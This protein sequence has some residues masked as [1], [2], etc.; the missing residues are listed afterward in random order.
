MSSVTF[1]PGDHILFKA[2]CS[3]EGQL[4]LHG[5]GSEDAPNVIDAYGTWESETDKPSIN[6]CG[7]VSAT[8]LLHNVE[9]WEINNLQVTNLGPERAQWRVAVLVSVENFG[10]MNHIHLLGLFI[11]DVNGELGV[12]GGGAGVRLSTNEAQALPSNLNDVLIENCHFLAVDNI[13]VHGGGG[14]PTT[15]VGP[16]ST[17]VCI[18][19]NFFEDIGGAAVCNIDTDGCVIEGNRVDRAVQREG[20]CAI[21]PWAANNTVI[22][23]NEVYNTGDIGDG[24]AFDS[25]YYCDGTIIQHNYSHDNPGGFLRICNGDPGAGH[26]NRNTVVRY[27]ISV[28][29]GDHDD[30]V[31]ELWKR[32]DNCRVYGNVVYVATG[33]RNVMLVDSNRYGGGEG[34]DQLLVRQRL[35]RVSL[36]YRPVSCHRR[37]NEPLV[38]QH[39]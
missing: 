31:I 30:A 24:E 36:Q 5:S 7:T 17:N 34:G 16:M 6:G 15:K 13:G 2:G 39:V 10:V 32:L 25:D 18:R 27:N 29:D 33:R 23:H 8:L 35:D 4:Q 37:L 26:Y 28:N 1:Q 3:W 12:F 19:D 21:W 11:H 38:E 22:Q 14:Y 9:Y 20:N